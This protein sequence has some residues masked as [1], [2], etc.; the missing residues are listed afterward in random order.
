MAATYALRRGFVSH[1]RRQQAAGWVGLVSFA[2]VL[3]LALESR[4]VAAV[5]CTFA[6]AA[7]LWL[8]GVWALPWSA[9]HYLRRIRS[10]WRD[11]AAAAESAYGAYL[12]DRQKLAG[13]LTHVRPPTGFEA[14]HAHLAAAVAAAQNAAKDRSRPL[15]ERGAEVAAVGRTL[16]RLRDELTA[17]AADEAERQYVANVAAVLDTGR[18]NYAETA[19]KVERATVEALR[20]L[21]RSRV[22][23]G[24]AAQHERLLNGFERYLEAMREFHAASQARDPDRVAAA[25]RN[26]ANASLEIR[27]AYEALAAQI[28]HS[29]CW[30]TA[31][32]GGSP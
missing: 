25:G 11:W 9:E 6:A 31:E 14:Q 19:A 29:A 23:R 1:R 15:A 22:P 10:A 12:R 3:L 5:S 17:R 26:I 27:A 18:S 30:S 7:L 2:V 21:R 20:K 32:T 4:W 13:R 24:A 8:S 16:A 28:A